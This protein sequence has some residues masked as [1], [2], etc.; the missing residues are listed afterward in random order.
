MAATH[1]SKE[2]VWLQ[3]LCSKIGFEQQVVR[4]DSG[5]QST[6]FLVKNPIY[7]LKTNNINV[8]YH[9]TRDME[10]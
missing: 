4:I 2:V 10:N 5:S 8:Q 1:V 7:N 3:R 9:F 6:I